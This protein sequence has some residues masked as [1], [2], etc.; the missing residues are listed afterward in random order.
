MPNHPSRTSD[1]RPSDLLR[2]LKSKDEIRAYYNKIARVYDLLAEHS[3]GPMRK[4]CIDLLNPQPGESL[5]EIGFGTGHSLVE[6]ADRVAPGGTVYGIDLSDEMLKLARDL[7][8]RRGVGDHVTL[9]QGDATA[10]PL[11]SNSVDGIFMSFTLE[12]FDTPEIPR[13]LAECRRVLVPGGRL[14]VVSVSR[15]QPR[16]PLTRAFEWTHEHFP[17]LLDCRP[18]HAS[19]AIETAG[20]RIDSSQV[21]RMWIPV[22]IVLG[23][24]ELHSRPT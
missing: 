9:W 18:I 19:R 15:E 24:K 16:D 6:L 14:A 23:L 8:T 3:E 12:L 13:V 4:V 2:V 17:N 11:S 10:L 22:E 20:F 5:L 21:Q 1:S 7:V